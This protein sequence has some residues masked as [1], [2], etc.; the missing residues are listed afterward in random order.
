MNIID[1]QFYRLA[2]EI[3]ALSRGALYEKMR[4]SFDGLSPDIRNRLS[5]YF[6]KFGFWGKLDPANGVFEEIELKAD[7]LHNH[8][9]D[10]VWLYGRL[11]DYRS[12]KTLYAVLNNWYAYDFK[13]TTQVK[14][15]AF[16]EY[17]D[18]DIIPD[19]HDEVF[20]DLGAYFGESTLSFVLNYGKEC[21]RRIY[22]YEITP[23]V[24][25]EL[26]K[27]LSVLPDV[28]CRM[29]GVA[30]REGAMKISVCPASI[31]A[32]TLSDQGE[33]EVMV[34]S[35]D[36]DISEPV[37]IIKADIE[38]GEQRALT[39]AKNH[40]VNDHPKLLFS[41]YHGNEDLWK[42]ARMIDEM[43][44]DYKFYMRLKGSV[45]YPTEITL[46]AI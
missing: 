39:G 3:S 44:S 5:V 25:A 32:N 46:F 36:A 33:I 1:L 20:V 38:G 24:F 10:F 2:E 31:S 29:K 6:G 7:E 30:D 45:V 27:T 28:D 26:E 34:T 35:L 16:D 43:S 4:T 41:V 12:K 8:I 37:S 42:I 40:I 15:Y 17:F 22:C 14:E 18:H 23:S 9:D 19:A 11:S 13:T 21:Y